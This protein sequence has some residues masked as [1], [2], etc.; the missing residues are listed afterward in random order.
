[1]APEGRLRA[2]HAQNDRDEKQ[3]SEEL[4][5]RLDVVD[6]EVKTKRLPRPRNEMVEPSPR[7]DA[8]ENGH[9]RRRHDQRRRQ[10]AGDRARRH[11]ETSEQ[12][13]KP[14]AKDVRLGPNSDGKE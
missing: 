13:A 4:R 9:D 11:G 10:E 7:A 8:L 14:H 6:E 2:L 1:M 5:P 12:R 3:R